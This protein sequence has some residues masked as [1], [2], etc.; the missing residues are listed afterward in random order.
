MKLQIEIDTKKVSKHKNT[1]S[2]R[3]AYTVQQKM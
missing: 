3:T 2:M 1:L